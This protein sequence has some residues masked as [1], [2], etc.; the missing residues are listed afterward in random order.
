MKS[1]LFFIILI[2]SINLSFAQDE[3]SD[4]NRKELTLRI[5][6]SK[7]SIVDQRMSAVKFKSWSPKYDVSYTKISAKR[8]SALRMQFTS[9]ESR[10]GG[11]LGLNSIRPNINYSYEWSIKDGIW[12]GGFFESNTLLNFSVER[13][14]VFTNN[15]INYIISESIGP[16]VTYSKRWFSEDVERAEFRSSVQASL[17][18]YVIQPAWGHPYPTQFLKEGTFN[19]ERNGMAWPIVKS[20]KLVSPVKHASFRIEFGFFYRVSDTFRV[21]VDFQGDV[22]YSN[23]RGKSVVLTSKDVFLGATIIH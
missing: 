6:F 18:S 11:L 9:I 4:L 2:G 23:S 1:I 15:T 16:R 5:G 14:G 12:V 20:G 3:L 21:G 19:P 22:M 17:L 10:N 8:I 13:S 7:N